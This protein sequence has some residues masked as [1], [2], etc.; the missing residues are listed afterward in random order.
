M[1]YLYAAQIAFTIWMVVDAYRRQADYFWYWVIL[2]L[3]PVGAWAYFFAVK[4]GD[5]HGLN[6]KGWSPFQ[7][8]TSLEELRYRAN[9]V[10]TLANHLALAQRLMEQGE[11]GEARSHLEKA[12]EPEHCQVLYSLAVCSAE[13]GHPQQAVPLLERIVARDRCWSDYA[14]W[15][16]LITTRTETGDRAGA[17][18]AC[19]E[20]VRLA[21]TLQHR[22]L[23]AEHL[24]DGGLTDEADRLLQQSLEDY[25]Y[26]PGPIRRRNRRWANQA[27]RLYKQVG[28][29]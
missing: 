10:P 5:F 24:L 1:D 11:H 27:K 9:Q 4:A 26:A 19:R 20:L 3:Q 6:F 2:L 17:L 16:L 18:A 22:C 29:R 28:S 23:L 15:R 13:E 7:R 25:H 14:A 21:P 12:M 8:R